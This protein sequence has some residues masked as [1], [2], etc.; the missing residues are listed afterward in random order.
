MIL[1]LL[2]RLGTLQKN[3]VGGGGDYKFS[4]RSVKPEVLWKHPRETSDES[5]QYKFEVPRTS[6]L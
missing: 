4:L 1:V 3:Q 6:L 2:I 5:L